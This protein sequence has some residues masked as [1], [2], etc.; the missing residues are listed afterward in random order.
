MINGYGGYAA[1]GAAGPGGIVGWS[2]EVPVAPNGPGN[3]PD[4]IHIILSNLSN[5][6]AAAIGQNQI[7]AA[8]VTVVFRLP[9]GTTNPNDLVAFTK[10]VKDPHPGTGQL[11]TD[12]P[13]VAIP[14]IDKGGLPHSAKCTALINNALASMYYTNEKIPDGVGISN[15]LKNTANSFLV[16]NNALEQ[17]YSCCEGQIIARLFDTAPPRGVPAHVG[18]AAAL[19]H[20]IIMDIIAQANSAYRIAEGKDV[21]SANDI[22]LVVLHIHSTQ[23]PCAKCTK[24]LAALSRIMN[25][26][27]PEGGS[28]ALN[29]VLRLCPAS[30][31][32]NLSAGNARFLIEVSSNREYVIA[33][34]N[35]ATCSEA[36]ATGLDGN[37]TNVPINISL[38][39][40]PLFPEGAS[41]K[42]KDVTAPATLNNALAIPFG[43]GNAHNWIFPNT[44]PPYVVFGRIT[45][46][47]QVGV[48]PI[49][50]VSAGTPAHAGA[51]G[52]AVQAVDVR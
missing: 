49:Q 5:S 47:G 46:T 23:D 7:A 45:A 8:A 15:H 40:V 4:R 44:F 50:H 18:P 29:D 38:T 17:Y 12:A 13:A 19:F 11:L 43:P 51:G 9:K 2:K 48:V 14:A 34:N 27:R 22:V 26:Y 35:S 30:L 33:A 28:Q 10:V 21:I 6:V 20:A 52:G 41:A 25:G 32:N 36:E 3:S 39:G 37:A 24:V 1:P 31:L 42:A 16:P